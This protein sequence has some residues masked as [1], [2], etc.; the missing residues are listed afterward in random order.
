[1]ITST[2]ALDQFKQQ[3]RSTKNQ[4]RSCE[5][6]GYCSRSIDT[7]VFLF[8][9]VQDDEECETGEHSILQLGIVVHDDSHL[10]RGKVAKRSINAQDTVRHSTKCRNHSISRIKRTIPM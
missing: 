7:T 10:K 3:K 5:K 8:L 6:E 9:S 4:S 1:M 2:I